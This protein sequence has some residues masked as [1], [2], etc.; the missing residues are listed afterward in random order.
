M[1]R[2]VITG[3][4]IVSSL[5][6]D[7][8]TVASHLREG[9]SGIKFQP[10]YAERG[11][12]TNV[13]GA[14]DVDLDQI[15]RKHR[16]F[17]GDAAAYAYLSMQQAIADSGLTPEQLSNPR[18]GLIA[19]SGGASNQNLI[20]ANA[21]MAEK[22]VKR[23][24]PYMVPRTMGS[25]VSA[26]LATPFE[27]KGVNYSISSACATSAHCIGNAYELIQ[28][29]KQDVVFAGGGEELHWSQT[30]LFD[31][32]G[33]LSSKYN[34][35][36][37][38]ASRAYS[39]DRDGFVISG[40]GGMVVVEALDHAL[41]RGAKI[42]GEIVGYGATSDGY[43]MVAPSGE[44]AIRCMQMAMSTVDGSIDYI[45]THGTSTPVG[46]TKEAGGIKVVFG[47]A[48]PRI[49]STKS[50]SGHSLGAAGVH[51]MIYCLLMM[52]GDFIAP[53]INITELDESVADMPIVR[54][55]QDN[56]GLQRIM[57]NSFGFG[58]TNATLV[59]QRY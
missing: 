7:A 39:A 9:K 22:G 2:V 29:G 18:T 19:G 1:R 45:N 44:G 57:S 4:G 20:E 3:L 47:D 43:D 15:D 36:P 14:I 38:T 58:G 53:S 5:G 28:L 23:I 26:C 48:I 54:E 33:A 32:M 30:M 50:M 12:R 16:R 10:A 56:A 6:N 51:E 52:Q 42:Y 40:G 46:D 21:I 11:F 37:E 34:E 17:M 41:A 49:S 31:A 27:I 13:E 55:R 24:G 35:T 25:T 59:V 8:A